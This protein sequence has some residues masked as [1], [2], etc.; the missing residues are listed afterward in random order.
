MGRDCANPD[1]KPAKMTFL[2]TSV[3]PSIGLS[4][5]LLKKPSYRD[6]EDASLST[7]ACLGLG[8]SDLFGFL[9]IY[10]SF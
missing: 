3:G 6:A 8:E 5:T 9:K 10:R 2:D 4:V 1:Y 7:W